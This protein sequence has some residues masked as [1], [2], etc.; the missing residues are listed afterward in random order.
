MT[1]I[2]RPA[3]DEAIRHRLAWIIQPKRAGSKA[4]RERVGAV[5]TAEQ[6]A[7]IVAGELR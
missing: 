5:W 6:K 1:A 2:R 7:Q 4:L 3:V